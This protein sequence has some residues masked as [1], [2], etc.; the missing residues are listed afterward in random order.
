MYV[1]LLVSVTF[2]TQIKQTRS[3]LLASTAL[4]LPVVDNNS[5]ASVPQRLTLSPPESPPVEAETAMWYPAGRSTP[6]RTKHSR[7]GPDS[8]DPVDTWGVVMM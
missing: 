2:T 5:P 1:I 8:P 7:R 6:S 3:Y 4:I